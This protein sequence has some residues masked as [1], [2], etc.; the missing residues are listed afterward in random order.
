MMCEGRSLLNTSAASSKIGCDEDPEVAAVKKYVKDL[1]KSRIFLGRYLERRLN[2]QLSCYRDIVL[3]SNA[4]TELKRDLLEA[5]AKLR[6]IFSNGLWIGVTNAEKIGNFS[7]VCIWTEIDDQPLGAFWF[8]IKSVKFRENEVLLVLKCIRHISD[9]YLEMEP[10]LTGLAKKNVESSENIL[11]N[12]VV[13]LKESYNDLLT[14]IKSALSITNVKEF[15]TFLI[16]FAIAV[17]TGS[18]SFVSFLGNFILALIREISI[19]VKNSTPMFL[20]ILDFFGKIVGGFYILLAMLFKPNTPVRVS[21]R[22]LPYDGQLHS[23]NKFS[24][25]DFD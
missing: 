1:L 18:T 19:F 14:S 13:S 15:F 24:G 21:R 8:Q 4:E 22:A 23:Y 2:D 16:A 25:K 7:G 10:I 12:S 9:A 11:D 6:S 20:G 3:L 17:V 5:E